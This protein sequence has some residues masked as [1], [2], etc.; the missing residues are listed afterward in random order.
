MRLKNTSLETMSL[1]N[2]RVEDFHGFL[3]YAF[4]FE[5]LTAT[6]TFPHDPH[7]QKPWFWRGRWFGHEPQ[8]DIALLNKGFYLAYIDTAQ[9]Y[10]SPDAV[11]VWN[12]YY[13]FLRKE[14][15]LAQKVA[16]IG[17]SQGALPVLNWCKHN[18]DKTACIYIDAGVCALDGWPNAMGIG[19][20]AKYYY[21]AVKDAYHLAT[22]DDMTTYQDQA[23][24]NLEGLAAERVPILAICGASDTTVPFEKNTKILAEHY[25]ALGGP[26]RVIL[27]PNNDHHP[28]SL[29]DPQIIVDFIEEN[30][31][32]LNRFMTAGNGMRNVLHK[33]HTDKTATVAFLGGSITEMN[34]YSRL[35]EENLRALFPECK[36][37]FINAGISSTCS[38][39][40]AFRFKR[41]VLAHGTPDLL[42]VDAAVNDNQ[43]GHFSYDHCIRSI[44]GIIWSARQANPY[45][46]IVLLFC[47]NES[48]IEQ[49]SKNSIKMSAENDGGAYN[50]A[51]GTPQIPHEILAQQ[52]LA[53]KYD[54][55]TI[56]FAY[57]VTERMRHLEFTWEEF[58]GVHPAPYGAQIYANDIKSFILGE[59]RRH[60]NDAPIAPPMNS[61]LMMDPYCYANGDLI[62]ADK[63]HII[64]NS[65]WE[66]CVPDWNAIPGDKRDRFTQE[67]TLCAS[68]PGA[69]I[70]VAFSGPT[71]GLYLT[72]GIDAGMIDYKI[73]DGDWMRADLF[74]PVWSR[75]LHYPYTHILQSV[76]PDGDH[77]LTMRICE[78][79]NEQSCGHAARIMAL[80][81]RS[82]VA[83]KLHELG[84]A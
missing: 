83:V 51:H 31:F 8:T 78:E 73:D 4:E 56:N 42:F 13:D 66:V 9:Y 3:Q 1:K 84:I 52:M 72:A 76:L 57:D 41:D 49:Y 37:N 46:S 62:A 47:T 2:Y 39:T 48:F 28:H 34:G 69:E 18:P 65:G 21:P 75:Y 25:R 80:A 35:T 11:A 22:A 82:Y 71:I 60:Q 67:Q 19:E 14:F 81:V 43:D 79:K 61:A 33:I 5:G 54:L 63:M 12:K 50:N 20:G 40:G 55:A 16:F 29:K 36:F 38:D 64:A 58:G 70:T 23:Y 45:V 74:Y 53:A 44:E 10:G 68:T 32:G 30:V 7:P 26:I 15:N 6:I 24:N 77:T 59:M 17:M 27:K